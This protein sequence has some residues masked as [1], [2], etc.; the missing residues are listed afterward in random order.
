MRMTEEIQNRIVSIALPLTDGNHEYFSGYILGDGVVITCLHGFLDPEENYDSDRNIVIR[1]QGFKE[2]ISFQ[3]KTVD[4]L[5]DTSGEK[6]ILFVA[7]EYDVALLKFSRP[8]VRFVNLQFPHVDKKGDWDA[9]GYPYFNIENKETGGYLNFSGIFTPVEAK[10]KFLRLHVEQPKLKNLE[11]WQ[12][13]SGAPVFIEKKLAGIICK[14]SL[15]PDVSDGEETQVQDELK[16]VCLKRLWDDPSEQKF[17]EIIQGL[18]CA[19]SAFRKKIEDL[20]TENSRLREQL[21]DHLKS[22]Q[23][24]LADAV[25]NLDKQQLMEMCSDLNRKEKLPGI[26]ELLLY[27]MAYHYENDVNAC[28]DQQSTEDKPYIDVPVVRVEACE[29]LMA[30][31]DE[32]SPVFQK[33]I[34]A[35][36]RNEVV[37]GKYSLLSPPEYGIHSNAAEDVMEQLLAGR[38]DMDCV[39]ERIFGD[40]RRA[41]HA[42]YDKEKRKKM[43]FSILKREEG[44]YYWLLD[45]ASGNTSH[46]QGIKGLPVSILNIPDDPDG[47]I[48]FAE[49]KLFSDLAVFIED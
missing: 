11:N 43:A 35:S 46:L 30:S 15:F 5:K 33:I 45:V 41:N 36:G 28:F 20:F 9:G 23:E 2:D 32:R 31:R 29:F 16:A 8:D 4:S 40:Y 6:L 21:V 34:G 13:V 47:E 39:L 27:A 1:S 26:R 3:G 25:L 37:P 18:R 12:S 10:G 49:E 42:R 38:G 19:S 22:D 14:Y 44:T 48:D 24:T 7:K 17:Q